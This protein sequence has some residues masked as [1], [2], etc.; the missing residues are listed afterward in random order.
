MDY[1][2]KKSSKEV[3][4]MGRKIQ[5]RNLS[6]GEKGNSMSIAMKIDPISKTSSIDAMLLVTAQTAA[7]IV[8]WDLVGEDGKKLPISI[9]TLNNVLA[10]EFVEELIETV[11]SSTQTGITESEKKD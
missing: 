8:D 7:S 2:M 1:L 9:D 6:H 11:Q 10:P 3:T 5:V 4:V